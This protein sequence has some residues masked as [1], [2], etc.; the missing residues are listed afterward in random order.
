LELGI[1][2]ISSLSYPVTTFWKKVQRDLP[3]IAKQVVLNNILPLATNYL[4]ETGFS[5]CTFIKTK[6]RNK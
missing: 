4:R 3:D 5:S 1:I 2:E 6:F